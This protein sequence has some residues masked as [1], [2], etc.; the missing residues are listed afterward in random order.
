VTQF[1]F[2]LRITNYEIFRETKNRPSA[3]QKVAQN[4]PSL[5]AC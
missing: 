1:N 4:Q 3:V 2:E 5:T